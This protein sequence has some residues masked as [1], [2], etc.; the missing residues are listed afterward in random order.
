MRIFGGDKIKPWM[1]RLGLQDGEAIE[2][3]MVT[4]SIQNAQKK[5]E[6]RNFD[7]RKHLLDY[8][9]VM[10]SQRQAF[11]TRR[12]DVLARGEDVHDEILDM[13]EG[14]IVALLDLHWPEKG[15]PEAEA[16]GDLAKA[17]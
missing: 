14:Q 12:R 16:L 4:R 8:D 1:E 13:T 9:N 5:V 3:R 10:N 17:L 6:A 7:I 15:E 2:H 11:Y